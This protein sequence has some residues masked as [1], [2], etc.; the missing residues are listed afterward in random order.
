MLKKYFN[1]KKIIPLLLVSFATFAQGQNTKECLVKLQQRLAPQ[2]NQEKIIGETISLK[3][4][5]T[6]FDWD[7]LIVNMASLDKKFIEK[8]MNIKIPFELDENYR[9]MHDSTAILLFV[10]DGVAVDYILQRGATDRETFDRAKTIKSYRFIDLVNS[11]GNDSFAKIPK[12]IAIFETYED[13]TGEQNPK[14]ASPI[15]V[16]EL[17]NKIPLHKGFLVS[18]SHIES[19][20]TI[21]ENGIP[22]NIAIETGNDIFVDIN[23]PMKVI[24]KSTNSEK[25]R[26][27]EKISIKN[28]FK[29]VK[30]YGKLINDPGWAYYIQ[31]PSGWCA[32]FEKYIEPI[33]NSPILFFFQKF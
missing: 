9:W 5:V 18:S 23:K 17:E 15:R 7:T 27:P 6:C 30:R 19:G 33:D 22:F 2:I 11:F 25:F 29:D 1:S 16:K 20:F 32:A 4:S 10:K 21:V 14:F 12:A 31:L 26:T 13:T 8:E 3:D 24:F 28:T